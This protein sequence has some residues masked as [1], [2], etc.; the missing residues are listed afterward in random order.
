M[1]SIHG[2]AKANPPTHTNTTEHKH[3]TLRINDPGKLK[4]YAGYEKIEFF[5]M[6]YFGKYDP[7]SSA[8]R[9][10]YA[11]APLRKTI[12]VIFRHYTSSGNQQVP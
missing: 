3:S 6:T 8:L 1:P 11:R 9:G 10:P 5:E 4:F 7:L 12:T 2:H